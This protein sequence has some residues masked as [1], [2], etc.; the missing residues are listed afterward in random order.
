[1]QS[2][3]GQ[4]W[5]QCLHCPKIWLLSSCLRNHYRK[6]LCASPLLFSFFFFCLTLSS[7]VSPPIS[8]S[9]LLHSASSRFYKYNSGTQVTE[10]ASR[11]GAL[12]TGGRATRLARCHSCVLPSS[13]Q[14]TER[15]SYSDDWQEGAGT[16]RLGVMLLT[17]TRGRCGMFVDTGL[18]R[19]T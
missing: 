15:R 8:S 12:L 1:M 5:D 4:R 10:R 18:C 13:N 19:F 7:L 14:L 16:V 2:E 6:N 17:A 9:P 3:M 11:I